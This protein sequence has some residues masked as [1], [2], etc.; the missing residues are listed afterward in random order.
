MQRKRFKYGISYRSLP[1]LYRIIAVLVAAVLVFGMY[2]YTD[3][4]EKELSSHNRRVLRAYARLWS[5]AATR[6]VGAEELN[7]IFEEII[8][9]S[10]FPMILTTNEGMPI[11][12]RNLPIEPNDTTERAREYIR[13]RLKAMD[14]SQAPIPIF[15]GNSNK[16]LGFIH[17]GE[18]KYMK[19]LRYLPL[20][21]LIML[22]GI[23]A[24]YYIGYNRLRHYEEQNIW[25]GMAKETAHQLGTPISSLMGWAE[26]LRSDLNK[27]NQKGIRFESG[28]DPSDIIDKIN[29][30]IEILNRI[31]VRFGQIGSVPELKLT[32]L[33][34]LLKGLVGYISERIP[35][36]GNRTEIIEKYDSV[37]LIMANRLLLSWAVENLIR[38][39]LEA[40]PKEGG[41]I[42]VATRKD[43]EGNHVQ[44]IVTDNG[45][46]IITRNA[47]KIFKPGYTTKKR[48]WGLGLS[49][50]KR[51]VEEYHFGKLTMLESVPFEKTTFVISFSLNAKRIG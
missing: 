42:T 27:C 47:Y 35:S 2:I 3:Y 13:K 16:I 50:A 12:W 24:L 1:H 33:N 21:E 11:L 51:I 6:S 45:R 22:A 9:K 38:N 39:S 14:S 10:T 31:V 17:F 5:L 8:Q 32:D 48:G 18:S 36:I 41:K 20:F 25:L 40:L 26:L 46:G 28:R 7:I 4:V 29:E 19:W 49:L 34:D 37:P 44:I 30:D 23:I 43:V 15:V